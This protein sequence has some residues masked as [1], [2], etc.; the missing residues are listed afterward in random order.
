MKK[1]TGTSRRPKAKP[2]D[3][4]A[5]VVL[6]MHRSGT[7]MLTGILDCLGCKGPKT[8]MEAN[9]ESP[10]G[11]FESQL[12]YQLNNE[13]LKT[14]GTCW[15]DW[16]P[17]QEGWLDS[18]RFNEFHV[19]AIE[20]LR[21]EYGDASMIYLK[22]PRIC[23]LFPLWRRALE[24]I[25]Y[26]VVC[27]HTHRHPVDVATSLSVRKNIEVEPSLGMLSW[28]RNILEAEAASR[29]L[30]RIFTSYAS[31]IQNWQEFAERAEVTFGFT[32]PV[33]AR[34]AQEKISQF[35][36]PSL[37]NH[38][39][40]I[41]SFLRDPLVPDLFRETLQILESWVQDGEQK[42][43]YAKLGK[44]HDGFDFSAPLL[45]APISALQ[46]ATR[47]VK[48]LTPHKASVEV[49]QNEINALTAKLTDI[50]GQR[51]QLSSQK[52]QLH[53]ELDQNRVDMEKAK[54]RA[55]ASE[56]EVYALTAKL[57]DAEG[58]RDQL[59]SQKEQLRAELDENR[60]DMEK[61]KSRAETS[62][63]EVDVLTAKVADAEEHASKLSDELAIWT[64]RLIDRDK[65][66]ALLQKEVDLNRSKMEARLR[67]LQNQH[68][69]VIED[70]HNTYRS[71]SSWKVSAPLR[72][73]KSWFSERR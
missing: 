64:D 19:R 50:E 59:F 23:R 55:E 34:T 6:G 58:Q 51:D 53:A 62:E 66:N 27:I 57:A 14:A 60:A 39:S 69:F 2:N 71:S 49:R 12:V 68:D 4:V 63:A 30:P 73:I 28:L 18:P 26:R 35:I 67:D 33:M 31:V 42:D 41:D 9:A 43:D 36:E 52:E 56:A 45:F 44:I 65:K 47:D 54:S 10:K 24:E 72:L 13:I 15:D 61:A 40:N 21:A 20:V 38:N 3:K 37:C 17:Q 11:F 22:D 16:K 29:D 5:I 32:W 25:G 1:R 7:S 46:A 48:A 8:P 70:L